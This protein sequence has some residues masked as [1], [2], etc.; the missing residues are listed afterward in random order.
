MTPSHPYIS[1]AVVI[2]ILICSLSTFI[3]L[4]TDQTREPI[5][6]AATYSH[7]WTFWSDY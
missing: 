1:G 2:Y 6:K 4:C 3:Y 5:I 7:Q